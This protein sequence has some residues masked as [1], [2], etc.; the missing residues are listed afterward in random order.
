MLLNS[1]SL[2]APPVQLLDSAIGSFGSFR[3]T[4]DG[5]A[6]VSSLPIPGGP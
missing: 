4:G 5:P 3:S 2:S 1:L 6:G